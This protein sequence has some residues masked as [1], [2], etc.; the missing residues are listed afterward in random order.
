MGRVLLEAMSAEKPLIAS[1]VGGIPTVF[2]DGV[3]GFLFDSGDADQLARHLEMLMGDEELRRRMGQAGRQRALAQ[4]TL[5]QYLDKI[6]AFYAD[7]AAR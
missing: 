5:E 1:R 6:A 4:F 3:E 2:D 7:A